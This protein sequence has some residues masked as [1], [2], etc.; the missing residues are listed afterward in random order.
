MAVWGD[1][2]NSSEMKRSKKQR[3]KGEIYPSEIRVR[4]NSKERLKKKKNL[5]K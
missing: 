1:L 2:T 3:R 5:P 4:K